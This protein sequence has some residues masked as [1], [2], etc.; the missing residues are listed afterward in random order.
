VGHGS[1]ALV[2]LV[3]HP[4]GF[5][6]V[7]AGLALLVLILVSRVTWRPT[8]PLRLAHRRAWGQILAASARMYVERVPLFLSLG[9]LFVPISLLITLLQAFILHATSIFGL[10]TGGE[11]SGL[12]AFCGW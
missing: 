8:A 5:A 7:L 1:V 2:R 9:V 11:S 4:L 12:A 6:L 10:Q 3:D